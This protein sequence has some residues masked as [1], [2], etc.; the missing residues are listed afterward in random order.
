MGIFDKIFGGKKKMEAIDISH[1][2]NSNVLVLQTDSKID[3]KDISSLFNN[4]RYSDIVIEDPNSYNG[5]LTILSKNISYRK[6]TI[7]DILKKWE[8]KT[9]LNIYGGYDTGKSHISL[10]LSNHLRNNYLSFS[11]KNLSKEEFKKTLL[12][13]T[14]KIISYDFSKITNPLIIFDDIPQLGSDN[15]TNQLFIQLFKYCNSNGIKIL[16]TSNYKIHLKITEQVNDNLVQL[17]VPL[18]NKE[19]IE[20]IISTYTNDKS[21]VSYSTIIEVISQGNPIY[22]QIICKYLESVKWSLSE[23]EF[24][25]FIS[26]KAFNEFDDEIYQKL[27][28]TTQDDK[29]REIL[30][31]LNIINGTISNEKIEIVCNVNPA[32]NYPFEKISNLSGTWLQKNSDQTYSVS[33]LIK[34]LGSNN[35]LLETKKEINNGLAHNILSK[36]NISQYDAQSAISHFIEGESF[37]DAGMVM[38]MGLQFYFNHPETYIETLF[39]KL[40]ISTDLPKKMSA[41]LKLAIRVLQLHILVDL[42]FKKHEKFDKKNKFF[43]RE[44]LEKIIQLEDVQPIEIKNLANL[45]L[46][47]SYTEDNVIRS[48][49]YF[50]LLNDNNQINYKE[51]DKTVFNNLWLTLDKI[52]EKFEIEKWFESFAKIEKS[53]DF[54]EEEIIHVFSRR[55]F[56][57][58]I[59]SKKDWYEILETLDF[60]VDKSIQNNLELL[61]AYSVKSKIFILSEKLN[62]LLEAELYFNSIKDS[63]IKPSAQFI[64]KD[65]F[66]RQQFYKE[67]KEEALI[68]LLDVL[69][70]EIYTLAR[71]DSLLTIARIFG[72]KDKNIAHFYTKKAVDF[73]HDKLKATKLSKS[74]IIC[75]YA[76]SFWLLKDSK[77][78]I[79]KFAESFEILLSSYEEIDNFSNIDD[80]NVIV[81]QIGSALNYIYQSLYFGKPPTKTEDGGEYLVPTRGIFNSNYDS[82][83]LNEWYYDERKYMN[84]YLLVQAFE[85]L[86]DKENAMKWANF[87]FELNKKINLLTFK[88]TLRSIIVYKILQNKYQETIEVEQELDEYENTINIEM[89]D[90]IINNQQRKMFVALFDK[91]PPLDGKDEYFFTHNLIPILLQE[92]TRL[93]ENKTNEKSIVANLKKHLSDTD[94]LYLDKQAIKHILYILENFP[95]NYHDCQKL[96]RWVNDIESENKRAI[97]IICY[98]ICSL[99]LSTNDALKLHLAVMPYLEKVIKG[100]SKGA[101]IFVL[102]QFVYKFWTQR[103]LTNPNDFNHLDKWQKN[104]NRSI[105]TKSEFKTLSIYA[106]IS[107]HLQYIPNEIEQEWML[108]YIDYVREEE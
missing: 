48:L 91:L 15:N 3:F 60:I 108:P 25:L 8:N 66:G 13:I 81:L 75:E 93:F 99:N 57:N 96:I 71:V 49:D 17:Q 43:I 29:S 38:A 32:I 61:G 52:S 53:E 107:M 4:N 35:L 68:N 2:N 28:D 39:S 55:L 104:L 103:V 78:A 16:S 63:F 26:G 65:E 82:K 83:L 21:K 94:F 59:E 72:E 27:L 12:I 92:L 54:F 86:N 56:D 1:L 51:Q 97:Q 79:Y 44:D 9:W 5:S 10:L 69:D 98:I 34:R 87:S 14:E 6:N 90:E 19:E 36:K 30:Y 80:H 7:N 37:D 58:I 85:Y 74:K 102:Y 33:P 20:E 41:T 106:L 67:K 101:H 46:F 50:I 70:V 31:R 23:D 11:F 100:L 89:A 18:L 73:L 84:C 45:I 76:I 77:T 22:V 47:K 95:Q 42:E 64:I 105:N 88:S 62:N 40:W 24:A